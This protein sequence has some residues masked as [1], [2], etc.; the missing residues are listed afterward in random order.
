MR[1]SEAGGGLEAEEGEDH[2]HFRIGY[3]HDVDFEIID[4]ILVAGSGQDYFSGETGR[5]DVFK[6]SGFDGFGHERFS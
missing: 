1:L 6:N 3:G 5:F 4:R 2:V